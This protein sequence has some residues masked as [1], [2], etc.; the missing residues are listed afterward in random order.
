MSL[1]ELA[2]HIAESLEWTETTMKEDGFAMDMVTYKPF[3][4]A[5]RE[6]L[7]AKL[8][9]Y[10]ATSL[11]SIRTTDDE[12]LGDMWTMSDAASGVVMFQM[13][14]GALLRSFILNHQYHHRGQLSV[15]LRLLDVPLPQIYGP[16]ADEM[17]MGA[18]A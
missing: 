18:P 4:P 8:D 6:E 7:L 10:L 12:R 16:T 13:P 15:Y 11:E 1:R 3:V 9:Q 2:G 17:E 14:R 5:S